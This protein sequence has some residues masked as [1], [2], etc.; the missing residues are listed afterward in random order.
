MDNGFPA[1]PVYHIVQK[2]EDLVVATHGRGLY[3]L[4][5][6]TPMRD[7]VAASKD[8]LFKPRDTYRFGYNFWQLYGGGVGGGQKKLLRSKP[9]ARTY[10]LRIRDR[11]WGNETQVY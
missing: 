3:I 4:D 8:Q 5:D 11:K 1:V 9:P 2:D 10:L 6:V 7:M